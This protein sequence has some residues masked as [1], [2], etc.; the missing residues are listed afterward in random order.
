VRDVS[1]C[2][3][4]VSSECDETEVNSGSCEN[5]FRFPFFLLI[6]G[7]RGGRRRGGGRAAAE[8]SSREDS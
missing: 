3:L 7:S 6:G 5:A 4:L 2:W 1:R 8:E